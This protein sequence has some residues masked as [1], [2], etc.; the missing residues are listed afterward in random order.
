MDWAN[1]GLVGLVK[2]VLGQQG[3]VVWADGGS[4]NKQMRIWLKIH[5]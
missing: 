3:L 4:T 5:K 1:N 2:G